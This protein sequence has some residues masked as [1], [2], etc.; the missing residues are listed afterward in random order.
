MRYVLPQNGPVVS[1]MSGRVRFH[2][3]VEASPAR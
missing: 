1:V 3:S 2:M